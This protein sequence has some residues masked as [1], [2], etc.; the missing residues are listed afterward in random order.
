MRIW[1]IVQAHGDPR[2]ITAAEFRTVM[3]GAMQGRASGI[4]MF[5]TRSVAE[6]PEKIDVLREL[7]LRPSR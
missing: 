3:T 5:T 1:P 7:Y 6:D 2:P 4:M